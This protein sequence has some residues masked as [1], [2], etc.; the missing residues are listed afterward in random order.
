MK[1]KGGKK[2]KKGGGVP[3]LFQNIAEKK[4]KKERTRERLQKKGKKW[5]LPPG[6]GKRALR[7]LSLESG[8][9]EE[10]GKGNI[11]YRNPNRGEEK[12]ENPLPLLEKKL[13]RG[14][15]EGGEEE[16]KGDP[17][18][19][20]REEEE[21]KGIDAIRGRRGKAG[22]KGGGGGLL[23][24]SS[25]KREKGR[26]ERRVNRLRKKETKKSRREKRGGITWTMSDTIPL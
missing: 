25:E 10:K 4:G 2:K 1:K 8:E 24:F 13:K 15:K 26:K 23:F 9:N 20:V 5:D 12:R 16:R 19:S 7:T 3:D 21:K 6:R 18:L 11:P 14:S 17:S 22:K